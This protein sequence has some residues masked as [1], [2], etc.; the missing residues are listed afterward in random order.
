MLYP[1]LFKYGQILRVTEKEKMGVN[2]CEKQRGGS[3]ESC[4]TMEPVLHNK[5]MLKL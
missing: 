2:G 3:F 5:G 4:M 1:V